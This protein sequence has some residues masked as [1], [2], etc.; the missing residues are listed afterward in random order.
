[1][2]QGGIKV[3]SVYLCQSNHL[4][5]ALL[6]IL[7]SEDEWLHSRFS[8][9]ELPDC[10]NPVVFNRREGAISCRI[11]GPSHIHFFSGETDSVFWVAEGWTA[12]NER[13]VESMMLQAATEWHAGNLHL[14]A[15]HSRLTRSFPD[16]FVVAMFQKMQPVALVLNDCFGRLPLYS[17]SS[18]SGFMISRQIFHVHDVF[19]GQM[20]DNKG[21]AFHLLLGFVPGDGTLWSNIKRVS[22]GQ[23]LH[24]GLHDVKV[25]TVNNALKIN[26]DASIRPVQLVD[27]TRKLLAQMADWFSH[28]RP[29]LS[30]SGGLDSRLLAQVFHHHQIPFRMVSYHDSAC[31]A[32]RDVDVARQVA[33]C[34]DMPLE[35]V[36]L[37]EASEASYRLLHRL[38]MGLNY[39]GMAF[40]IPFLRGFSANE[41]VLTGDGGDKLLAPLGGL[42]PFAGM[43]GLAGFVIRKHALMPL[44]WAEAI[45]GLEEG[46]IKQLLHQELMALF[47][48]DAAQTYA[49]FLL[50]GRAFKWLFEGEDRN[51]WFANHQA[52]LWS[53]PLASFLLSVPMAEKENYR[54]FSKLLYGYHPQAAGVANANWGFEVG[55]TNAIRWLLLKQKI[56]HS[57]FVNLIPKKLSPPASSSSLPLFLAEVV[58]WLNSV[59]LS[60]TLG[61]SLSEEHYCYLRSMME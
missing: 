31:S 14:S 20:A 42:P 33:R 34:L 11:A 19:P 4:P 41:L 38:K 37:D 53:E 51:R 21:R 40:L 18:G 25:K 54:L 49:D 6:S 55:R 47:R 5:M 28:T 60:Q 45:S 58:P 22:P 43:K 46:A 52:P 35:V 23:A 50:R 44:K 9:S 39:C 59:G 24:V 13:I 29:A 10:A 32:S 1:M 3:V 56:K 26:P 61:P 12:G 48:I 27:H 36:S 7:V 15:F 57:G 30:M 17:C 16:G 2:L 8:G